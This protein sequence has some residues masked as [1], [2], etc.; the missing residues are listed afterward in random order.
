MEYDFV[1]KKNNNTDCGY[2]WVICYRR[3]AMCFQC[4]SKIIVNKDLKMILRQ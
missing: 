4:W 3:T 1:T 2:I